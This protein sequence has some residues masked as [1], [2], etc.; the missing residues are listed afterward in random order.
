MGSKATP[1]T[2]ESGIGKSARTDAEGGTEPEYCSVY[3]CGGRTVENGRY[4]RE[5]RTQGA[6][7]DGE[8]A[9]RLASKLGGNRRPSYLRGVSDE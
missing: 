3:M 4:C 8:T 6:P 9:D 1:T 2:S 5:H 7:L